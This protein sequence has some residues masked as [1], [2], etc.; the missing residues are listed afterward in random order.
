M[1]TW[2]SGDETSYAFQEDCLHKNKVPE[3]RTGILVLVRWAA[4]A[5]ICTAVKGFT[6]LWIFFGYMCSTVATLFKQVKPKQKV[7]L[8]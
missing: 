1:G 5:V 4:I 6:L 2:W 7:I 8:A 3:W